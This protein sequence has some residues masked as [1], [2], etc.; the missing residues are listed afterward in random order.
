MKNECPPL[1]E[2][3]LVVSKCFEFGQVFNFVYG[4]LVSE[5]SS[6]YSQNINPLPHN[7]TF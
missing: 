3:R 5:R 1:S 2:S 7:T 6:H 4:I